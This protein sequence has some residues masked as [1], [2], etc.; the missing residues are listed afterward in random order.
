MES[1]AAT[2]QY[3]TQELGVQHI[4]AATMMEGDDDKSSAKGSSKASTPHY[5]V[6]WCQSPTALIIG[7][8]GSGLSESI[9]HALRHDETNEKSNLGAVHIPMVDGI[10]SLNAAVCGSVI[11]FEYLRQC[12]VGQ[13]QL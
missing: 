3:L 8:E 13:E 7:S 5:Q 6:D 4:W 1:W 9:R 12:Q 11:M 10:E 2:E